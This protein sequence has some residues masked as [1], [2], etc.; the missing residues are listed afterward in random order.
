MSTAETQVTRGV[1][2]WAVDP[3]HSHVEFT[4]KHM[5]ITT[6]K[7]RFGGVGGVVRTNESDA[8]A[9]AIDI[10][11]DTASVDTGAEQRDAHLRSADFFDVASHPRL[12][13]RGGPV[14]AAF[15]EPGDQFALA[16]ELTIR[17]TTRDVELVVTYD[18]RGPDPWGGERMSFSASTTIDR[19]DFG[20]TWNQG[21]EAGGVL[22]GTDIRVN[23]DVQLVRE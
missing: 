19:R 16:G 22:V 4:V 8:G 15:S 18:G 5:M 10:E 17:G 2:T 21:L 12:T 23:L 1:E 13:F 7:G 11:I 3:T 6:V 20:L 9:W 14:R